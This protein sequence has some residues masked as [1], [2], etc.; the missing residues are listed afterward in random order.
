MPMPSRSPGLTSWR[1]WSKT[2]RGS[3]V[4][5]PKKRC[6][7]WLS[8]IMVPSQWRVWTTHRFVQNVGAEGLNFTHTDTSVAPKYFL[9]P[10][11]HCPMTSRAKEAAVQLQMLHRP[12]SCLNLICQ[13]SK[14]NMQERLRMPSCEVVLMVFIVESISKNGHVETHCLFLGGPAPAVIKAWSLQQLIDSMA[15]SF[16]FV[17]Y[18]P[19]GNCTT[20]SRI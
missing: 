19:G 8:L 7:G 4:S 11:P 3:S 12:Q 10:V 6:L 18:S 9:Q 14:T 1:Q 20:S 16:Y 13:M 17:P 15:S 5:E 2:Q